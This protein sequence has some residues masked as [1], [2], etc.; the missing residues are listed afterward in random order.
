M[1]ENHEDIEK[2]YPIPYKANT[3]DSASSLLNEQIHSEPIQPHHTSPPSSVSGSLSSQ[4]DIPSPHDG[5]KFESNYRTALHFNLLNNENIG[6][7]PNSAISIF[8]GRSF[9]S[10]V[11]DEGR[12]LDQDTCEKLMGIPGH[13]C[14]PATVS[15]E[16]GGRLDAEFNTAQE[17]RLAEAAARN[18][19]YFEQE[20]DK[21]DNWADDLKENLEYELKEIASDIRALKREARLAATLEDKVALQKRLRD[22]EKRQTEKRKHL[23]DAHDEIDQKRD[24]L[25]TNTQDRLKQKVETKVLFTIR[26][27][28]V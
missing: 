2:V 24:D 19:S 4:Q 17:A 23:F 13:T 16:V 7:C 14:D 9:G 15:E 5:K 26:W 27:S 3:S 18:L 1:G 10:G 6:Y 28:V 20:S 12:S 21:L 11:T 22:M 8:K 25:I